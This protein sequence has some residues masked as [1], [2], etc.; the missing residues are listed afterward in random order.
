MVN[1]K[2]KDH[3]TNID[4]DQPAT[5]IHSNLALSC[6]RLCPGIPKTRSGLLQTQSRIHKFSMVFGKGEQFFKDTLQFFMFLYKNAAVKY[7]SNKDIFSNM[8]NNAW[9][10][11][12]NDTCTFYMAKEN[13]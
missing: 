6:S 11:D 5:S 4:P 3:A 9:F 2:S 8:C 7:L 10:S 12:T 1:V 13:R